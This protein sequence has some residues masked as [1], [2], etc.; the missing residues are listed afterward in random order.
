M[1]NLNIMCPRANPY[2]YGYKKKFIF[3]KNLIQKDKLPQSLMITGDRGIGKETF[4][5]HLLHFYFD[6]KNYN[7]KDN[8]FNDK[9]IFHSKF[10]NHF[11]VVFI[12]LNWVGFFKT[13]FLCFRRS[14]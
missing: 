8:H 6:K 9:S 14:I 1:T 7:E 5:N 13:N 3:F 10:I 11:I 2:L 4:V 12:F